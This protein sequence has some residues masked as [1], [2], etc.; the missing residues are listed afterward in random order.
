MV[1]GVLGGLA[2]FFKVDSTILRLVYIAIVA[3]TGFI[4]G[5]LA[6]ALAAIVIPER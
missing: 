3:F 4:P 6:Y 5:I 1:A 2:T